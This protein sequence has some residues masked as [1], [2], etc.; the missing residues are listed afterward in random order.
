MNKKFISY[1]EIRRNSF[2]LAD[3]IYSDDFIPDI[4]YS[5]LRGG[6]YLGNII[7]E[8]FKV[9][10][11]KRILYAAVV[12]RSYTN[13]MEQEEIKIDGW[14][15]E[16]SLLNSSD[17]ILMIDDIYDSGTTM[18]SLLR[19]LVAYGLKEENIRIA[20]Y[21]YKYYEY[22]KQERIKPYYYCKKHIIKEPKKNTWVHYLT[23][24]ILGMNLDEIEKFYD[25]EELKNI[26]KKLK[27]KDEE[28][29]CKKLKTGYDF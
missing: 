12:A 16:P 14:T 24:E 18:N 2:K 1:E 11:D 15:Y 10:L 4:I 5:C 22:K 29:N 21:D 28:R 20:V 8:Y 9:A 19:I 23:H 26:L 17:K 3:K 6:A 7:S 13:L 27:K 25:D